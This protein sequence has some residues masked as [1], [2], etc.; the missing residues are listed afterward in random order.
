MNRNKSP[1][2]KRMKLQIRNPK[3]VGFLLTRLYSAMNQMTLLADFVGTGRTGHRK[4]S[5]AK[6][7]DHPNS[8]RSKQRCYFT[9]S[10]NM[11]QSIRINNSLVI[12]V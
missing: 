6:N 1:H 9:E 5:L 8:H 7:V 11:Q 12:H 4:T 10:F 3:R 2:Y